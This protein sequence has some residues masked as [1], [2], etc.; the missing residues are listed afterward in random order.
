MVTRPIRYTYILAKDFVEFVSH[1]HRRDDVF[2]R[3][4]IHTGTVI[5]AV[6]KTLRAMMKEIREL[7][8]TITGDDEHHPDKRGIA[9]Q[10]Q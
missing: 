9:E 7:V 3:L 10:T 5:D 2:Q 6:H 8:G 4:L 1:F